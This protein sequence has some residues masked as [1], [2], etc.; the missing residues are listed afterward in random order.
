MPTC[1]ATQPARTILDGRGS[2]ESIIGDERGRL[3]YTDAGQQA[4]MR[5]DGPGATPKVL[6]RVEA[7]GG[8][9]LEP[10]GKLLL[11]SGNSIPA[12]A[13]GNIAPAARLLRVDPETG[14]TTTIASGLAMAN[15]LARA[16]DGT[17]YASD[18]V[19]I[20][21]DRVAPGGARV[22]N[23]WATVISSN[24]LAIS[25]DGRYLYAAQTFEP[26][27]IVRIE[28]AEP[29]RVERY[30]TPELGDVAAGPDGMTIDEQGRLF[31]AANEIS[32]EVREICERYGVQY[33]SGPLPKQFGSVVRKICRLAL[34][35]RLRGG[36]TSGDTPAEKP[37]A[38]ECEL[39]AAA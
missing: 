29:A 25:P 35:D 13:I 8:L 12:G 16:S 24:G 2:L 21:D 27:A 20:G 17:V 23:G 5:L 34:P 33:N 14:V 32:V 39:A 28:I 30:A 22:Q 7:G 3:F 37:H 26:A 4:L 38:E 10:D 15:G 1:P 36:S 9:A 11:G 31:V 6:T 19:G 18:D